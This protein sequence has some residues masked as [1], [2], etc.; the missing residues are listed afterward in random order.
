MKDG[1]TAPPVV[2]WETTLS[3][4]GFRSS[5]FGPTVPVDLAAA[6]VWQPPQPAL[7]KIFAPFAGSPWVAP[8]VLVPPE[9]SVGVLCVSAG[10]LW[11]SAAVSA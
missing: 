2:T 7:A 3:N 5:R 10:V 8:P 1:I 4:A 6:S 9:V 11:V